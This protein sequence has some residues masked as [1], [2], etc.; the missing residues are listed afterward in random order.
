MENVAFDYNAEK[1][2]HLL[3]PAGLFLTCG[4]A[5][6]Y[7]TMTIGWGN[8]GINWS[9]PCFTVLVA[10]SR[11]THDFFDRFDTFTVTVPY[12]DQKELLKLVGTQSGRIIKK[13]DNKIVP[14]NSGVAIATPH[15]ACQGMVYECHVIARY[16]TTKELLD[17]VIYQKRYAATDNFHTV[18]VGQIM[19]SYL[20]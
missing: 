1:N 17:P 6:A 9:Q 16:Q 4:D 8:I 7:N 18:Y 3:Y 14:M 19:A 5:V 12:D 20:Q 15:V 11:Y 10:K 2:L 13:T